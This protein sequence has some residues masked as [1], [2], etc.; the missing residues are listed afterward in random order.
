VLTCGLVRA[1][2]NVVTAHNDIARTGQ[3]L[4][5]TILTP[6]N[7]NPS[8]FGK[9]FSWKLNGNVAAQPLYVSNVT[10]PGKGVHNVVYA[11]TG[12][13]SVYAIDADTNGGVSA[14]FLWQLSLTDNS[15]PAGTYLSSNGVFG[16]PTIDPTSN[17]MYLVS[18][19]N[20]G[21]NAVYRLHGLDITTGAE[22]FGGPVVIRASIQGTGSGSSG[23]VLSFD[24]ITQYQRAGL[25]LLNGVVYIAFGSVDDN[26]SWHGWVFSYNAK[27]LAQI[28]VF[29]TTPNGSGGGIWMG[30][31]GLAAEV[32]NPAKPYGRMFFATGNG[33]F[34]ASA[35]YTRA[36]SY[37]MSVVE[38]DL[39]G[40]VFTVADDFTPYNQ[41][42]LDGQDGDLGSG[43]PLLLP[44]QTLSSGSTLYPLL[45]AG[46]SGKIY[47]LDRNKLGGFNATADQ[48][49]QEVQ[50]PIFNSH[51]WGAGIWGS[52][53]YW[54][55]NIYYGGMYPLSTN[56]VNA[57]SFVKGVLSTNPTSDT[58]QE[59]TYPGPTPSVSSNGTSSGIVW[60]L[61]HG[62]GTLGSSALLAYDATNLGNLLYSS[63]TVLS[64]DYPGATVKFTVPTIAHG[65]VYVGTQNQMNVYGLLGVTPTVAA[66]VISPPGVTFTGSQ[67]VTITDA[68]PGAQI[69][70][71]INGTTPTVGSK[72]YSKPFTITTNTT[73]TAMATATGYLQGTPVSAVFSS[74]ANA[75]NPV[76]SLASGTYGG[77][78]TLTI[79][80]GA[81]KASIYYTVDGTSPTTASTPY[82]GPIP[83][84]VNET[85]QAIATAPGLLPSSV[86]SATYN[87]NP[88]YDINFSQ[89]FAESQQ[90]GLMKFNG[91]TTLDDFRLQ[92]TDGQT[93]EAG[94]AFYTTPVQIYSFTTDFTFQLS[95]PAGDGITFTIQGNAPTALG[96]NAR[97][98]GYGGIPNSIGI[99]FNIYNNSAGLSIGGANPAVSTIS[100]ANTGV[101][102]ASG[103]YMNVHITY[104]SQILNLTITDAVTLASWSHGFKISI[105]FHLGGSSAGYV[106]F[107]GG[108]GGA[109]ASQKVTYWTYLAG[110]PPVPNFISN[111]DSSNFKLQGGAAIS[112]ANLQ[113][114]NGGQNATT[115]AYYKIPVGIQSFTTD[116]N[117]QIMPGSVTTLADGFTFVIQNAGL[118]AQGSGAGGLGYAGI[119]NSVAIKF[120]TFN[121]A[122][123]GT[124]S[125]GLYVN[126][127]MPTVPSMDLTSSN[128]I[129]G[130][131]HLF[132]V[133]I[134]YDG[135]TLTWSVRDITHGQSTSR[136]LTINIP[137]AISSNIAYVGFTAASGDGASIQNIL[138]WTFTEGDAIATPL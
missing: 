36:M 108:T 65:K 34:A 95:N 123:E 64:R 69:Y 19:E 78:Q 70:Y 92:L 137:N 136:H 10:I 32:N 103:D 28:D 126:G 24:P 131:G 121:N 49:P 84:A 56:S 135:T 31:S 93:N 29:C 44:P 68:T 97:D 129:I 51:G 133:H 13:D 40:G 53:A 50:T 125:T 38:L 5:E 72:L 7:V 47:I 58:P 16:T 98:L 94:S 1:Q 41:A 27:T 12:G 87:I 88:A 21:S 81:A 15:T 67:V 62:T 22:K 79:T 124:D 107:T 76:F 115:S 74:T 106:G 130:N 89:G 116:F 11:V 120:D 17:T 90:A 127:A 110:P 60:V 54:N 112:G 18:S 8:Q 26:A 132:N 105:P 122:G 102:L 128:D 96:A 117:F 101:N 80:D 57:Y 66:P 138:Q 30:G 104:D 86:V 42:L 83:V 23:G 119:P 109:T 39:S 85:V 91:S 114:T 59:F 48:V 118:T 35:P 20:Q 37:G 9:L 73:I 52:E 45:Q 61:E 43:G 25:L 77:S 3:N 111:M 33:S 75:A 113:L 134:V 55:G 63:N 2:V 100:L 4:N 71:T 82:R 14:T 6:A 46:K 99:A